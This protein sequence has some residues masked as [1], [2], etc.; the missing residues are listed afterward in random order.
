[1][2][3][4]GKE[5]KAQKPFNHVLKVQNGRIDVKDLFRRMDERLKEKQEAKNGQIGS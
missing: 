3:R 1:M 2:A 5:K 4:D